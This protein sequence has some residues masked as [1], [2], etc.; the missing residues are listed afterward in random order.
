MERTIS[1]EIEIKFGHELASKDNLPTTDDY[2]EITEKLLKA[3][4][5]MEISNDYFV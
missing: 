5:H 3:E 1:V 2:M 4:E